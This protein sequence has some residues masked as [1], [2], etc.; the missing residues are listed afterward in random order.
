[1]ISKNNKK[2][3][4]FSPLFRNKLEK[5]PHKIK[6]AFRESLETFLEDQDHI[7]LRNHLLTKEYAGIRSIDVTGDWRA[8]YKEEVKRII[9]VELGTHEDLYS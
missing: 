2:R 5:V 3:I 8:L 4:E 1:M 7:S 9:F 6:I